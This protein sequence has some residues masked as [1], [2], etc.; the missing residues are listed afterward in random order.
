M[1]AP[2]ISETKCWTIVRDAQALALQSANDHVSIEDICRSLAISRR[3]LQLS[4]QRALGI[5]PASYLR[6]VRLNAARRTLKECGS[7]TEAA[8]AWGFWHFGRF[9]QDY[10]AMFGEHPSQTAKQ[11]ARLRHP[12]RG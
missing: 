12:E 9:A 10:K 8:T 7:V 5:R 11:H 3:T 6:A 2:S 4:F 1:P